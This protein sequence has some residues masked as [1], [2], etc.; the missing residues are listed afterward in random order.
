MLSE[1]MRP[2]VDWG[3][4]RPEE[5]GV[6][7]LLYELLGTKV[8]PSLQIALS[9]VEAKSLPKLNLRL[10]YYGQNTILLNIPWTAGNEMRMPSCQL[11]WQALLIILVSVS[12]LGHPGKRF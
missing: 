8:L 7:L 4:E 3:S 10:V 9:V 2:G 11:F 1:S 12:L 6:S 5:W